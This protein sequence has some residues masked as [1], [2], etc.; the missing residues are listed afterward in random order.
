MDPCACAWSWCAHTRLAKL[1]QE[2]QLSMYLV[3]GLDPYLHTQYALADDEGVQQQLEKDKA[4]AIPKASRVTPPPPKPSAGHCI[5]GVPVSTVCLCHSQNCVTLVLI[6]TY[7]A[8]IC[9]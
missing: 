4:S 3:G 2:Q 6:L 9:D 7:V 5:L 8:F 1:H